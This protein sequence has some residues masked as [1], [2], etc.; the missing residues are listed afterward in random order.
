MKNTEINFFNKWSVK[1]IKITDSGLQKYINLTPV[2]F[3]KTG[4]K[5]TKS[6]F[7]KSKTS[8]IERLINRLFVVGHKGK[9]H[10][11]TSGTNVGKTIR[12]MNSVYKAFEDI[13]LKLKK[14]PIEVLVMAIQNSAPIEEVVS[15]QRRAIVVRDIT[16]TSPQRRVDLALRHI[17]QG[18]YRNSFNKKTTLWRAL[19]QEIIN[20]YNNNSNS[21]AIF[22]KERREKEAMGAR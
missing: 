8:I 9:K 4:G 7:A 19:S 5:N 21:Y 14:N 18:T 6:P 11:I 1:D 20:A 17:C 22:E 16:L 15:F 2:Y 13:E 3:P 12:A 10:K